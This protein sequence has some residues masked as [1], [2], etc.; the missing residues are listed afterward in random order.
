M[1]RKEVIGLEIACKSDVAYIAG[2]S[3]MQK[4]A[5]M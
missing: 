5:Q 2:E 1:K 4:N 3:L